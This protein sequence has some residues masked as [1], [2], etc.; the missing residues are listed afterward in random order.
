LVPTTAEPTALLHRKHDLGF[1]QV[2]A[3]KK[4]GLAWFPNQGIL[5][6]AYL[7]VSENKTGP[8]ILSICARRTRFPVSISSNAL[9]ST[10]SGT[11]P[12]GRRIKTGSQKKH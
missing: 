10:R 5:D 9:F 8:K 1:H 6:E 7:D 4:D 3:L 11:C 2:A 12:L